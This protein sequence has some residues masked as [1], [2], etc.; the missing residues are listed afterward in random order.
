MIYRFSTLSSTNDEARNARYQHGDIIVAE[1]QSAGRGQRGHLW[2]SAR[3]ENLTFSVVL[4]PNFLVVTE[5]FLLSEVVALS[6]IDTLARYALDARIKWT[7]DI[8]VGDRKI[9]GVL[10]EQNISSGVISRSIVGIG[11]NV[12]QTKF[13]DALPNPVSIAQLLQKEIDREVLIQ[14]FYTSLMTRYS[15]LEQGDKESIQQEYRRHMYRLG[16]ESPFR[17]PSGEVIRGTICG[18]KPS[19]ELMIQD[20]SGRVEEYLFRQIEFVI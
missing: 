9:T 19:G 8:Y 13:D 14:T 17:L 11:I 4:C 1:F 2:S 12:N 15:Q 20:D 10:I 18:V 16:V 6:L 7:N 5:Q 3:A